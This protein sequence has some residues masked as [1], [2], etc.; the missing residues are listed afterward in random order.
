MIKFDG[1]SKLT[2][3]TQAL[4]IERPKLSILIGCLLFLSFVP[5]LFLIENDF[6]VK[7]WF[8]KEDPLIH[9]L[10]DFESTFGNDESIVISITHENDLFTKKGINLIQKLS[11]KMEEFSGITK[12]TSLTNYNWIHAEGDDI[13]IDPLFDDSSQL[14]DKY[15]KS[16]KMI[17][18]NHKVIKNYLVEESGKTTLIFGKIR[19]SITTIG[20][21]SEYVDNNAYYVLIVKQVEELVAEIKKEYPNFIF[22]FAGPPVINDQFKSAAEKDSTV[23]MPIMFVML[24]IFLVFSFRRFTGVLF[25]MIIIGSSILMTLGFS[26]L[27]GVKM[28]NMTHLIP[29][30]LVA[31]S[32]A[33]TVHIMT[34]FFQYHRRGESQKS[35]AL[36]SLE[37]NLWPTFL[38]SLSTSIGFLSLCVSPLNLILDLGIMASFG[39]MM[40]WLLTLIFVIPLLIV[41]PIKHKKEDHT[42]K[43]LHLSEDFVNKY[44]GFIKKYRK[45]IM[46]F[47]F[48]ISIGSIILGTKI[49][50]NAN[51][52]EYFPKKS[53]IITAHD[54]I[55]EEI[56][57][58]MGPE[59]VIETKES[60]GAKNPVVLQKVDKLQTWLES[61]PFVNRTIS[62]TNVI[63]EMNKTLNQDDESFYKIP[64]DRNQIAEIL[65]LYTMGLPE[66]SSITEH[67]SMDESK[68]RVSVLWSLHD[69]NES[70]KYLRL[71][72]AK[73]KELG[74]NGYNTGKIPLYKEMTGHIVTTFLSSIGLAVFIVSLLMLLVLRSLKLAFLSMLPNI[75]PL[76][77]GG[78]FLVL[79]NKELDI[80]CA[81]V[82][83]VALGIAVDDTIH[84]LA[85]Y[86]KQL[87]TGVSSENAIKDVII[88]TGPALISTTIILFFAFGCFA[89]ADF[90]PNVYFGIL[91][92]LILI[93]AL[94]VDLVFLPAL[95]IKQKK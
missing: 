83:S 51:P 10:E 27:I 89:F 63:K 22:H 2:E 38:T 31:I 61:F 90:V 88:H 93:S 59:I 50:V 1:K 87:E 53:P 11:S 68:L 74:L 20:N 19:S 32:I 79:L 58:T 66:G 15:I 95:L 72:E 36:I 40:A 33:D 8:A 14:T 6:G 49:K 91:I 48:G 92:S 64:N 82:S 54:Y 7:N 62:I 28:S 3:L 4:V 52:L 35:A 46:L 71:I 45:G 76:C 12:V 42:N 60:G 84:F 41:L 39:T 43:I 16:K 47:F 85:N 30:I 80:G 70:L 73:I 44:V 78:G 37:K 13:F 77:F 5:G 55:Q 9:K 56:G 18:L 23:L 65:L 94:V 67:M 75:I 21:D 34:T 57:G 69:S 86:L 17:A 26:G 25:P 29:G 81:I 24:V